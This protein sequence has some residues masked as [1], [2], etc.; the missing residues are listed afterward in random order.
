ML[1]L[2]LKEE[3]KEIKKEYLFRFITILFLGISSILILVVVSLIPSYFLLKV[4]QKVVGQELSVAQDVEL[5]ADRQRLKEKLSEL[6]KT[7]NVVDTKY[8]AVSLYLQ[9]ITEKQPRDINILSIDFSKSNE[10]NSVV[11]Q[12]T[13][14]SRGSLASFVD[15]LE[16]VPQFESVNLPFSS[17]ARDSDIPFSI[18]INLVTENKN[19]K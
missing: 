14:N 7:L 9:S 10:I 5:N 1:N 18:T 3:K 16:T 17:F 8:P 15:S 2:L 4:D 13:A 12:G 6:Q 19:E 11:L